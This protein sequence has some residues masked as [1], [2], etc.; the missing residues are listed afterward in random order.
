M[1]NLIRDILQRFGYD[2]VKTGLPYI[3]KT[4][5]DVYVHVGGFRLL[6]P[7][8]NPQ[9]SNYQIYP[10]LNASFG[11][12]ASKVAE[13]HSGMWMIDVGANVGDT[14]AVVRARINNPI[15][16][17]EGDVAT[18]QYLEKN[19]SLFSD[20]TRICTFLGEKPSAIRARSEKRGWNTTI[21]PDP[22]GTETLTIQTLDDVLKSAGL[23]D[24]PFKLLKVDVEGFDTIVLRGAIETIQAHHPVIFFEYN[25]A[26][27][28]EIGE[29]GLSTLL[30]LGAAGYDRAGFFDHKGTLLAVTRL[31]QADVISSLHRYVSAPRNLAGYYDICLF[32]Q[33]DTRLAELY[34]EQEME[35]QER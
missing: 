35:L 27:M 7:G 23:F 29:D 18:F 31:S 16:A 32:H 12:L 5:G 19:A 24:R 13:S 14:I 20:V 10:E 17:I 26:N 33:T 8:Y 1:K 30:S 15:V 3:P 2:I 28:K 21:I 4:R 6:M 22:N 11:R 25:R 9:S 34:F